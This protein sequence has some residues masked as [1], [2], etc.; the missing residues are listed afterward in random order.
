MHNRVV[1]IHQTNFFPWLGY[2]AKICRADVFVFLDDV[3]FPKK[4]GTWIN[5][6]KILDNTSERWLTAPINRAYSGTRKINEMR[7]S[8]ESD[9]RE[10]TVRMVTDKYGR[11]KH[12]DALMPQ[13]SPLIMNSE[14]GIA[15][16]NVQ[17]VS[18]LV[19]L[20]GLDG[21][22]LVRSS[23]LGVLSTSTERLIDITKAVGGRSYLSGDGAAGYQQDELFGPAGLDLVYNNFRCEPYDQVG[24]G[25]FVP[26][27]SVIDALFNVGIDGV[28]SLLDV[29]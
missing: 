1:A 17:S 25:E 15:E 28:R 13:L 4:G 16:Y 9:W 6:V 3:Q 21:T 24:G 27:L 23:E 10:K 14:Q 18:T 26:G 2:F 20:L 8:D 22:E 19:K 29:G 7:F 12:F 11:S 5:R